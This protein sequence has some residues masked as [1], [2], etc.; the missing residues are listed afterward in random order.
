MATDNPPN[1]L[2][3]IKLNPQFSSPDSGPVPVTH[4]E[5]SAYSMTTKRNLI[6]YLHR[7]DFILVFSTWKKA[8][9]AGYFATWTCLTYELILNHLPLYLYTT[10][11]NLR[12]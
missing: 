6:K 8:I 2:Y 4:A 1:G 3:Y 5:N 11:C 12:K 9:D 7:A 10:K